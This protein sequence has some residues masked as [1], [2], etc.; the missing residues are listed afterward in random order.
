MWFLCGFE[1][2]AK[3]HHRAYIATM[4]GI[5]VGSQGNVREFFS[6]NPVATFPSLSAVTLQWNCWTMSH[7]VMSTL[8]HTCTFLDIFVPYI[9]HKWSLEWEGV[10][11]AMTFAL[12]LYLKGYLAVTLPISWIIFIRDTNTLLTWNCIEHCS[13]SW[14]LS[15][16][17]IVH[18]HPCPHEFISI[19]IWIFH[20]THFMHNWIYV[21]SIMHILY[22]F[23]T[24]LQRVI[25]I[26]DWL[27]S[28]QHN[29]EVTRVNF[30]ML[31]D[32]GLKY[33]FIHERIKWAQRFMNYLECEHPKSWLTLLGRVMHVQNGKLG[34]Y[35]FSWWI[36]ARPSLFPRPSLFHRQ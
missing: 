34:H 36:D 9:W 8:Q 27:T 25:L 6:T 30:C 1:Y 11:H 19:T 4:T 7:L 22:L 5:C 28:W 32:T 26:L 33:W 10:L 17:I 18:S 23:V 3:N 13:H 35:W 21:I 20:V 24:V 12:G 29:N 16:Q 15:P 31:Q 14:K 2:I